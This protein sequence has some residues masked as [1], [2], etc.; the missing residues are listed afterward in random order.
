METLEKIFMAT[1]SNDYNE[2]N[3]DLSLKPENIEYK[4]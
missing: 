2:Y 3:L 4:K 1:V